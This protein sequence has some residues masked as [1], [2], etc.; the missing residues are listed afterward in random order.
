MTKNKVLCIVPL[1]NKIN[2]L[3]YSIGSVLNQPDADITMVIVDDCST[4]GSY[5]W[6]QEHVGHFP[7]VHILRNDENKGCY[8][9]RNRG[10]NYA[11]ENNIEFD[12]YTV[13][14]PDDISMEN[15]FRDLIRAFNE[16]PQVLV[17]QN[18]YYRYNIDTKEVITTNFE[19]ME[20]SAW[21]ARKAFDILGYWDNTL[22]MSG[23]TEYI[24]R[25][26]NYFAKQNIDYNQ[27]V[28]KMDVPMVYCLLDNEG[29]NLTSLYT[30][31]HPKR[32]AVFNYVDEFTTHG[33]VEECYYGFENTGHTY[34]GMGA[35]SFGN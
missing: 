23:D 9:S 25:L 34:S 29:Q 19:A 17:I 32:R 13:T 26:Y 7:N 15:R 12:F 6:C 28:G 10:L 35:P 20:G 33:K 1:Y 16:N 18:P 24:I 11:I 8:K 30:A 31:D 5:E 2:F 3:G 14:D 21:F 4:D 22:R 27:Y